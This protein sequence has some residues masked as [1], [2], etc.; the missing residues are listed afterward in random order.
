MAETTNV[1]IAD[2]ANAMMEDFSKKITKVPNVKYWLNNNLPTE[3]VNHGGET[4]INFILQ[5][6]LP[7]SAYLSKEGEVSP[8][9]AQ[10]DFEKGQLYIKKIIA[11]MRFTEETVFLN[12]GAQAIVKNLENITEGTIEAFNM[13]RE[14]QMHQNGDGILATATS[15]TAT[16]D[17]HQVMVVDSAR[18][19][20]KGMLLDCYNDVTLVS[21]HLRVTDV[22]YDTN[23]VSMTDEDD[24]SGVLVAG[25]HLLPHAS[26]IGSSTIITTKFCNGI[27]TLI[28]DTDTPFGTA[29]TMG[30]DRD[31]QSFAQACVKYG[32]SSGTDEALTLSRMRSVMDSIDINWGRSWPTIGYCPPGVLNA[33]NDV[34]KNGQQPTLA[35]PAEDGWPEGVAFIYNGKRVRIVSSRLALDNTLFF[36]NPSTITKYKAADTGWDTFAGTFQKVASYQM[37]ERMYRGWENYACTNFRANGRLNDISHAT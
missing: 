23:T 27:E 30:F 4:L 32:A 9:A 20:R 28:N 13:M 21:D 6:Q 5:T 15:I 33:Y 12:K 36:I 22:N 17:I 18:W 10:P 29:V 31:T 11:P 2:F 7:E 35:M 3:T 25:Y 26:F 8:S 19:I 14:F 1:T 37:F 16:T 24:A 34:L